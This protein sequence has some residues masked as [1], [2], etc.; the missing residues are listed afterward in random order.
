MPETDT[1]PVLPG[2]EIWPRAGDPS[3]AETLCTES[4]ILRRC[5][6]PSSATADP[7]GWTVAVACAA[8]FCGLGA[9]GCFPQPGKKR[10]LSQRTAAGRKSRAARPRNGGARSTRHHDRHPGCGQPERRNAEK[11]A[12]AL[13]AVSSASGCNAVP[14]ACG[15]ESIWPGNPIS[16]PGD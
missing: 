5:A 15:K 1:A 6:F 14:G 12:D 11:R 10:C 13:P 2:A 7:A 16:Q 9:A 3:V 4:E 8:A